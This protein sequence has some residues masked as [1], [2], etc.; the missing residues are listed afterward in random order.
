L[1]RTVHGPQE[2]PLGIVTAILGAPF[3]LTLVLRN[4]AAEV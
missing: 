3:F 2:T 1:A 4:R